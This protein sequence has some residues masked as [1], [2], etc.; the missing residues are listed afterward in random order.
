MD[1]NLKKQTSEFWFILLLIVGYVIAS[2][3][4]VPLNVENSRLFA[5]PYRIAVFIFSFFVIYKNFKWEK[6]T[7]ISMISFILFWI[8]YA[9][10]SVISFNSDQ[11]LPEFLQNT[12]E[13]YIR[14][15]VIAIVPCVALM[16]I[17][18][19]KIDLALLVKYFY[20]IF[21]VM[22]S[23]NLIYGAVMPHID[24]RLTSIFT[25]YYI[26]YGH[27]GTTLALIS[28]FLLMF[29]KNLI[30]KYLVVYGLFLGLATILIATARSPFLALMIVSLYFVVLK[31][32]WKLYFIYF[33]TIAFLIA[34]IYFY[35]Q[36]GRTYF[37]FIN[38][39][40][41]WIFD[42]NNSLR[43][44]LFERSL[45]I[46][47]EDPLFG[48]RTLYEDGMYPHNLFLE[49]L[50]ATGIVGF[51]LYFIKFIPVVKTWK[52]Y[53][54]TKYNVYYLFFGALF[55][56]YFALVITSYNLY[57]V[58]EFLY[59]SSIIIGISLNYSTEITIQKQSNN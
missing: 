19:K 5:V 54:T 16:M 14:L 40:Y 46:F 59:F 43:T 23:F 27:F 42:G 3:I 22:L 10:K 50:M 11:Y 28:M 29:N 33:G 25:V 39:T 55:L 51:V 38:R 49:L 45:V 56:Q 17:D 35:V 7:N 1:V 34:G 26:S 36:S 48:G 12:N 41:S 57:S 24:L 53:L 58:P 32:N 2:S 6:V 18:Y 20:Y 8:L 21:I 31:R 44:P 52:W 47:K 15:L 9:V 30:S 13:V 37:S 4:A